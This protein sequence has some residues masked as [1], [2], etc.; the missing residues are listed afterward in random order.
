[1]LWSTLNATAQ[2]ILLNFQELIFECVQKTSPDKNYYAEKQGDDFHYLTQ[3]L[4]PLMNGIISFDSDPQLIDAK[5]E[6]LKN[7]FKEKS[8]PLTWF[9]PHDIDL[10]QPVESIFAKQDFY[11]MGKYTS[12][13]VE[14]KKVRNLSIKL[15]KEAATI[16]LVEKEEQFEDFMQ[17]TKD[18]YGMPSDSLSAMTRLYS[19]YLFSDKIKLYL[20]E[21][22]SKPVAT[23]LGFHDNDT[24]GLYNGATLEAYRKQGLLTALMI[25]AVKDAP[26]ANYVVAQLMAAQNARGICDK[27][28]FKEYA[29][30]IPLCHGFDLNAI[31]A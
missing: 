22:E 4:F 11:P 19:A 16:N 1:M 3:I 15:N 28:G 9:W 6:L 25:N 30:F 31:S 7:Q 12:V 5:C 29:H 2:S 18:V 27:L 10:P 26:T 20:A 21:V 17:I 14:A 23:L 8:Y 24:L 13:A